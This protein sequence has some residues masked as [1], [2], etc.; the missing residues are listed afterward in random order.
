MFNAVYEEALAGRDS[1]FV[2]RVGQAYLAQL[3]S[4]FAFAERLSAETFGR[5][6]A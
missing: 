3:D 5:V 1:A 6:G 4:A 2:R